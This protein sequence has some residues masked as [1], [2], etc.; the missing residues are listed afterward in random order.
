MLILYRTL[1]DIGIIR[2]T[3]RLRYELRKKLDLILPKFIKLNIL[4]MVSGTPDWTSKDII[5]TI[6]K[7]KQYI[8]KY[9]VPKKIYFEFLNERKILKYPISWNNKNWARLWQFN[10]HYFDWGIFW[11]D[12]LINNKG[13]MH[14]LYL[15][16]YL[17]DE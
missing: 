10:L 14:N 13:N 8:K 11:I 4:C 16:D 6:L 9:E 15:L 12:D 7:R 1:K 3:L 17:I 2:I 5:F